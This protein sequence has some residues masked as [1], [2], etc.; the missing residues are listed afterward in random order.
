MKIY[1]KIIV[2]LTIALLYPKIAD[3]QDPIRKVENITILNLKGDE[4]QIPYWGEKNLLIF[5]VDPDR[6]GQNQ[7]FTDEL[8]SSKR[9]EGENLV[10][11]GVMNLKDAPLIPNK[12]ARTM[13]EK[14]TEKNKAVVLS[15]EGRILSTEWELGDCN[16]KFVT[17]LINREGEIVYIKKGEFTEDDKIEFLTLIDI[18]K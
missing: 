14:R 7:K 1:N 18:M 6:A 11:M 15:D 13:A 3:A 10:G 8:E 16:N 5:Y 17:L 12:L 2:I 9:A 4:A